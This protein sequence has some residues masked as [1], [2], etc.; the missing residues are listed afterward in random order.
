MGR[1]SWEVFWKPLMNKKFG[2]FSKVIPASWFWARVKSRTASLGYPEGGFKALAKTI[3]D[4]I[5]KQKGMIIYNVRVES[6]FRKGKK[7][8]IKTLDDKTYDFDRV[9]CTLP[10]PLFTKITK[11]LPKKYLRSIK[12]L[13]GIGASNLVLSLKNKFFEDGTYWLNINE[14]EFPFLCIV[15]HTNFIDKKNYGKDNI[16]YVGNYLE[17][18]HKY[19]SFSEKQLTSEYFPYLKKINKKFRKSWIKKAWLFKA[20]FAQPIVTKGYS[21][22]IPPVTTPIDGLYLANIQ[23]VYPWDRGTNYAVDLGNKVADIILND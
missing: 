10:V 18:S 9:I 20:P 22:K 21:K 13:M 7:I 3:T 6:I 16:I 19:F 17:T 23:Q 4:R 5:V 12:P 14:M 2:R 8:I 11:G 1:E 15:E